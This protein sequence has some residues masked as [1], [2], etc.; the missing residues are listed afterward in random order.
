MERFEVDGTSL[1]SW[2]IQVQAPNER[3]AVEE[4]KR[5]AGWIDP[6]SGMVT[7]NA[8]QHHIVG[9]GPADSNVV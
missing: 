1:V 6:P 8:A 4:A 5:I 3:E 9:W 2:T 7:V